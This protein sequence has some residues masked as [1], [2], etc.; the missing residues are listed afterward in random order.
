MC[1][2]ITDL[3]VYVCVCVCVCVFLFIVYAPSHLC[4]SYT[5]YP[6]IFVSI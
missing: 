3:F 6:S 1:F 4:Y 2:I 5:K